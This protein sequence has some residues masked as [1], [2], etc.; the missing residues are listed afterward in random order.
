MSTQIENMMQ[1]WVTNNE[2]LSIHE[3]MMMADEIIE[4]G[5]VSKYS[6]LER[7]SSEDREYW[8]GDIISFTLPT[9][10]TRIELSKGK[11]AGQISVGY[12][13]RSIFRIEG[14]A[15]GCDVEPR[16]LSGVAASFAMDE[17]ETIIVG[18]YRVTNVEKIEV[19]GYV[20][21][22]YTLKLI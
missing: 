12:T 10:F 22:M 17:K 3:K 11:A 4:N 6:I 14:K 1:K 20:L 8:K 19:F 15:I 21:P 13:T 9:S 2:Q 18:A 16:M 7:V 5:M